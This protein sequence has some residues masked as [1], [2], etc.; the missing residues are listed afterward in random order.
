M[1]VSLS[2]ELLGKLVSVIAAVF[3]FIWAFEKWWKRDEHFPRVNFD[4]AANIIDEKDDLIIVDVIS[5]LENKGYVPLKIQNFDCE[6]R[7]IKSGDNLELGGEAIRNQLNFCH[8]VA[9]GC[10]FPK[11][12][13]YSFIYPSVKTD[14]NFI[15]VVPSS[16]EY[17][18]VKGRFNYYKSTRGHHAGVVLKIPNKSLQ[19]NADASVE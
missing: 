4:I 18:L 8:E 6:I 15:T 19:R 2:F 16:C 10:F 17:L 12:W 1:E 14:Y 5:T 13:K 11:E 3:G 7:A 9:N